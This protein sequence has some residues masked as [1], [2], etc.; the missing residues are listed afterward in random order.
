M[1]KDTVQPLSASAGRALG[2]LMTKFKH[3]GGFNFDVYSKLYN[4][5]VDPVLTYGAGL[6]AQGG[7]SYNSLDVILENDNSINPLFT[8]FTLL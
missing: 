6:W 7:H 5:L 8:Y 4:S 2:A 1:L 3:C